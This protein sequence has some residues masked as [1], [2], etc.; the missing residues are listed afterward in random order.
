VAEERAAARSRTPWRRLL[1]LASGGEE[2]LTKRER[3]ILGC[4][5]QGLATAA[6]ADRLSISRTTVRNHTQRILTKLGVH[7]R[8][9]A[10]VAGFTT[11]VIAVPAV[12]SEPR[13]T[14]DADAFASLK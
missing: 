11:G 8:L 10:V 12:A 1:P 3:E 13:P 6:I 7:T 9:A 2:R 4:L 14:A 5:A